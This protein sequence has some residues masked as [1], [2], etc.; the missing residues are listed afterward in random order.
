[1]ECRATN[2]EKESELLKGQ[3]ADIK[4]QLMEVSSSYS[5]VDSWSLYTI[6]LFNNIFIYIHYIICLMMPTLLD[7]P[8]MI[9]LF[10]GLSFV[11]FFL[12]VNS[13]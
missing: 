8:S 3:L 13:K 9:S 5:F 2:A 11:A 4:K 6:Y 12:N 7:S 1:M 10:R